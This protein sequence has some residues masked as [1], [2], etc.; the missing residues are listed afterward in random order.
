MRLA[1]QFLRYAIQLSQHGSQLAVTLM[2][3]FPVCDLLQFR[4]EVRASF[5]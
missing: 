2:I 4:G 5:Q 1:I 3:N